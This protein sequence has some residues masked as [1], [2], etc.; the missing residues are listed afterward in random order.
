[1]RWL[2]TPVALLATAVCAAIAVLAWHDYTTTVEWQKSSQLLLERRADEAL[3]L[4]ATA[5]SRDM[6]GAQSSVLTAF[7]PAELTDDG[8]HEMRLPALVV[9]SRT[10][11]ADRIVDA[12]LRIEVN[13]IAPHSLDDLFPRDEGA[14]LF[15]EQDEEFQRLAF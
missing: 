1:L 9:E 5:F 10:D 7:G 14:A 4:L 13:V 11:L 12:A 8:L 3:E 2:R 6:R 15:H